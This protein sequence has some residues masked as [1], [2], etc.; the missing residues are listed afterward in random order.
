MCVEIT[1]YCLIAVFKLVNI[2]KIGVYLKAKEKKTKRKKRKNK[3]KKL[4]N[5][6]VSLFDYGYLSF[7]LFK[8]FPPKQGDKKQ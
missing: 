5:N 2:S 3:E 8:T 4:L 1:N 7:L 6:N